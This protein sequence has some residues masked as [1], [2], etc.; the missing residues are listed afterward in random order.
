MNRTSIIRILYKSIAVAL[1]SYGI[2]YGLSAEFEVSGSLIVLKQSARNLF[3][4]VPM[5]FAVIVL[6]SMSVFHSVRY[7]QLSDPDRNFEGNLLL[8]D[9]KA[10]ES[11]V[12]GVLFNAL[13]LITGSIWSRVAWGVDLPDTDF[14]AW[15]VWDPIQVCA[16]VALL[17]YLAYFLLRSSFAEPT[18]RA[19]TS[20]VYNIFAFA[21]LIP[22]FFIIPKMLDGLHP[23]AQKGPII[24]NKS[25]LGNNFRMLLYP[26]MFGFIMLGVWM[27]ELQSRYHSVRTRFE[28]WQADKEWEST[29]GKA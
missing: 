5:W 3:Y 9:A 4:H 17:I 16:L 2:F 1:L 24:F 10:K 25:D 20:A 6:M 11:A 14:S 21:T 13:G 23:T 7:L 15:W 29:K 26:T 22:L 28:A 12:I 18:Q 8:I 27:F 19:R